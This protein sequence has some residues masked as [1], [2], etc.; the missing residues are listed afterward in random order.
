MKILN[1]LLFAALTAFFTA[2]PPRANAASEESVD[3]F[4]NALQ[5]QGDWM[6]VADYGYVWHPNGVSEDWRPYTDGHW[7]YTDAGW[8]FVSDEPWGWATYHYGRWVQLADVGWSWVP[9]TEWAPAWVSWRRSDKYVGWAP[10]PPEAHFRKDVGFE[11]W[12]DS[13]Y[14]IGPESYT[15]VEKRRLGS[16]HLRTVIVQPKENVTII[17]ETTNITQITYRQDTVY[18][19][20]PDYEVISRE[21]AEPIPRL[22]IERRTDVSFDPGALRSE[23]FATHVQGDRLAIVAPQIRASTT[24]IAPAKVTR[25]IENV[26]VERGWQGISDQA[27]AQQLRAKIQS[28]AK[29][30]ASL[31]PKPKFERTVVSGATNRGAGPAETGA[32][33]EAS[34]GA[35]TG[36]TGGNR[37]RLGQRM[38]DTTAETSPAASPM[39][40]PT[41][42]EGARHR[43][44]SATAT[45]S[46]GAASST[47]TSPAESAATPKGAR[48]GKPAA[49]TGE[50]ANPDHPASET[51]P[52]PGESG[53]KKHKGA[54]TGAV[55]VSPSESNAATSPATEKSA[56]GKK[57]RGEGESSTPAT[58]N[59]STDEQPAGANRERGGAKREK[60]KSENYGGAGATAPSSSESTDRSRGGS[61]RESGGDGEREHGANAA[62][63]ER[64]G[65]SERN[66]SGA[67]A[68]GGAGAEHERKAGQ[69]T[70]ERSHAGA[71]G[72]G[73]EARGAG[74]P[75]GASGA[76]G[77]EKKDKAESGT[78]APTE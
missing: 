6:E 37:S 71:P 28:E 17:R 76:A 77:E 2:S 70:G 12:V 38:R 10:L 54:A 60:G 48:R 7:V 41:A 11:K 44:Q 64:G 18:V 55:S 22:R 74:K 21:S 73:V 24:S 1:A 52:T 35:A 8:T 62:G 34:P 39:T 69:G 32:N 31:P 47:E 20:G 78:A 57:A 61:A 13:Y 30:P 50:S 43:G 45:A 67:D 16:P 68:V 23:R 46:P 49:T 65:K 51:S 29:A 26:R 56:R 25:K 9:D 58:M 63:A 14:D 72:S 53:G 27:Q 42:R 66:S 75:G 19:G 33:A 15:F 4:Y 59:Q 36:E 40:S 3:L 5:P